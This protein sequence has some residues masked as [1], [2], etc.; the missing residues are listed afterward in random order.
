MTTHLINGQAYPGMTLSPHVEGEYTDQVD[1][2][3]IPGSLPSTL[4][5]LNQEPGLEWVAT[6]VLAE[7]GG[8]L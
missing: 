1:A 6:D 4:T 2:T 3:A 7:V 8:V 5:E